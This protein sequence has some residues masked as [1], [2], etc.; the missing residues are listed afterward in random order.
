MEL[1]YKIWFI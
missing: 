1:W